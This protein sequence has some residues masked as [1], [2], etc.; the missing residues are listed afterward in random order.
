[1]P[2]SALISRVDKRGR[3]MYFKKKA[4]GKLMRVKGPKAQAKAVFNRRSKAS[5][6][7]DLSRAATKTTSIKKYKANPAAYDFPGVDTK[8]RGKGKK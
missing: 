1:M 6:K 8:R 5:K 4:N 2:K 3:R 7:A